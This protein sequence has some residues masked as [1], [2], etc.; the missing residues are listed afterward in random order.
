MW[1]RVGVY[2]VLPPGGGGGGATPRQLG[3]QSNWGAVTRYVCASIPPKYMVGLM[4]Q[5]IMSASASYYF[6]Y[7]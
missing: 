5:L 3:Y 1:P 4:R 2:S 6:S 7:S